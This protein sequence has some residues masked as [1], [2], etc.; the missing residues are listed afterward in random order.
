MKKIAVILGL[1]LFAACQSGDQNSEAKAF[2]YERQELQGGKILLCYRFQSP[3]AIVQDSAV[4]ENFSIPQDSAIVLF[5]R[6]DPRESRLL[7]AS[8]K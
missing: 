2:I 4:V 7:L 5:D 8:T 6:Q 3:E 1:F